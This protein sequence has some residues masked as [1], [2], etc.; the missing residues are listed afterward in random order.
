MVTLPT[1]SEISTIQW[2]FEKKTGSYSGAITEFD[3]AVW[4]TLDVAAG[5]SY[6]LSAQSFAYYGNEPI[7]SVYSSTG[8]LI[9]ESSFSTLAQ[10][11]LNPTATGRLYIE[12]K[13]I[14]NY[15]GMVDFSVTDVAAT[16]SFDDDE[17]TGNDQYTGTYGERIFG[18]FG[19]DH[20]EIGTGLDASGGRGDDYILGNNDANR[21]WGDHGE[22]RLT[23]Q[24]GDDLLWGGTGQ[25]ELSGGDGNDQ[26]FGGD[27]FGRL[28]GDNGNDRLYGGNVSDLLDGGAGSDIMYGGAGNDRYAVDSLG[29]RTF[30]TAGNGI[31]LVYSDIEWTLGQYLEDLRL[32]GATNINGTGNS[33][34]NTVTGNEGNNVLSGLAGNDRLFGQDGG[35]KVYGG[36]GNDLLDG[37]AYSDL[38][39]GDAG[40][41]VIL[42][43]VGADT[44]HGGAGADRLTG[45]AN[46][47]TFVFMGIGD[48][49]AASSGRDTIVDFAR[50]DADKIDLFAVDANSILSGNQV[51][52]YLGSGAYT[53]SAGELR[54]VVKN[55]DTF[56]YGDVNGD[57]ATDF[58]IMLDTS[59][60]IYST[61]FIL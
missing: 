2:D 1:S 32:T 44:L 42:G 38:L 25:D 47:D 52:K 37:G 46:K 48:T 50:A 30:E 56:I 6:Y 14:S 59:A 31:D 22:D 10:A 55:G 9:A 29:D 20:I 60:R 7:M 11:T 35:D 27:D 17:N 13:N 33:G 54:A 24:G 45:G 41:D 8:E 15:P 12:L 23:G 61:D 26:L 39:Q 21:I 53:K 51:F 28:Y 18:L 58:S 43:G 40:N 16:T 49:T 3:G 34:T 5:K 4:L 19:D 36:T 57:A